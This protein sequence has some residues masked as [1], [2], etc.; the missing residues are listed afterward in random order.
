[1]GLNGGDSSSKEGW[2][3]CHLAGTGCTGGEQGVEVSAGGSTVPARST[4]P[5]L[6]REGAGR[7]SGRVGRCLAG[8]QYRVSSALVLE[9]EPSVPYQGAGL[10][11]CQLE[12]ARK[13]V[14]VVV[15]VADALEGLP[16]AY[17]PG[18][19]KAVSPQLWP[20]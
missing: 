11:A 1:L 9:A 8:V 4:P 3:G 5:A 2:I 10:W 7:L 17:K 16:V 14:L 13:G 20:P 6:G 18:K 15:L 19:Q 12:A